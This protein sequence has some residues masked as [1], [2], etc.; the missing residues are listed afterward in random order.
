MWVW[1]TQGEC[2]YFRVWLT[3]SALW[4]NSLTAA[5]DTCEFLVT[6]FWCDFKPIYTLIKEWN[7]TILACRLN[8]LTAFCHSSHLLIPRLMK[9]SHTFLKVWRR[10]HS[11]ASQLLYARTKH[12]DYQHNS[13][14]ITNCVL[15]EYSG[16]IKVKLNRQA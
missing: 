11:R 8:C 9:R 3:A 15:K 12:E 7:Q 10:P 16:F 1:E 2:V 13:K 5:P 14:T 6:S 4:T